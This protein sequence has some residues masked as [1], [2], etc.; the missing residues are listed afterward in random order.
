MKFVLQLLLCIL[1]AGAAY[2]QPAITPHVV[3]KTK[4]FRIAKNCNFQKYWYEVVL[5]DKKAQDSINHQLSRIFSGDF[6]TPN[7][8]DYCDHNNEYSYNCEVACINQSFFSLIIEYNLF[9][10]GAQHGYVNFST[11]NF[12]TTTGK[13]LSFSDMVLPEKKAQLDSVMM[14]RLSMRYRCNPIPCNLVDASEQLNNLDFK[15]DGHSLVI[16]FHME[17]FGAEIEQP[18]SLEELDSYMKPGYL[19]Y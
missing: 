18:W 17:S 4:T 14:L 15:F 7:A 11:L 10:K 16:L 2:A 5:L 1:I 19:G 13:L 6:F 12:N 3:K 9:Y 8:D